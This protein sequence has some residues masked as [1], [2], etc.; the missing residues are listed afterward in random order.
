MKKVLL[1]LL[2][3]TISHFTWAQQVLQVKG[4]V[5][6]KN[7]NPLPGATVTVKGTTTATQTDENGNF[8][9]NAEKGQTL[10]FTYTGLQTAEASITGTNT[11]TVSLNEGSQMDEVVVIG[12]GTIKKKDLTG[13]VASVTGKDLQSNLAKSAAGALQGRIA[14]VSVSNAGGTPGAG[15]SINIRGL[16]SLRSN[17][18]LYVIDGVFGDINLVDPNDIAS[19]EVLKDASAAAI[20]GSRAANGVVIVTT[21]GGRKNSPAVIGINAFTGVQSLPKK[22]D[23]MS[24]PQWKA[25]EKENGLLPAQAE[26]FMAN[27]NWQNEVFHTAPINKV[28][29]DVS[30]GGERST[31]NVSAGYMDQDGILK[32]TGYKAFTIRTKNTFSFFNDHFRMGNT[33]LIKSGDRKYSDLTITDVL[34]QNALLPIYDPAILGGYAT[35][36]PWMKNLEN[37]VGFL[38]LHNKHVYQT[39]IMLNGYAEADLF[40]KGL[41]YRLNVGIN[42]TTGRNYDRGLAY[43]YGTANQQSYLNENAFF[44]N[45][46]LIENTLHYDRTL[47]K[48]TI[49][50]LA[51]YS[52][53]EN[54]SRG[55]GASRKDLPSGTDAINAG[56]LP[57]QSTSGSL[58]EAALISQFGRLVYS[59]DSRYLLT[60]SLRRDGSSKFEDGHRY[61]VFPSIALGWNVMNERFFEAAKNTVNELKVRASYGRLGNQEIPNYTTQNITT[62]GINYIQGGKLWP[63]SITGINWVSRPD[64]T[65]EETVTSNIGL[66]LA[67]LRNKL[68]ISAD[69][70][71]RDTRGVLLNIN[72][73]PSTG[74]TGSPVM[75]A[76]TISN[77]GFEFLATYRNAVGALNYTIGVNA[78]TV[79]NE[80]SAVTVGTVQQFEGFNPRG[81]G[82][83]SWAKVGY[84]IGGFW[85]I[86]TDG[87][88]Q[89]DAEAQA[90]KDAN[91]NVIQPKARGGDIKFVDFNG[92]GRIDNN[93]RQYVGSPFPKLAYGIR[94]GLDYK[95]VDLAFFFDGMY[96]NKIYNYTR[97]R[98]EQ[99]NEVNNHSASLLNSWTPSNTNTDI[100]RYTREDPNDNKRRVSDRWIESGAFF[101]LKTVELGYTL[102]KQWLSKA[103]LKNG[104]IFLAADNLFTATKY[105][106]YTPDL[107]QSNGENGD[108]TG[109]FSAGTDYGRF[110]L[111]R[112]IMFG[113]QANF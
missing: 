105:K 74:L 86:K 101:R 61:G 106:G 67:F 2:L 82:V 23:L 102:P 11:I 107:G 15:L 90:Y 10:E 24:G 44:N 65:W 71:I 109:V 57:D 34:R 51:G 87:L 35:Y 53:Q 28:N 22:M 98:M 63:G 91:G 13:A 12:Y 4:T 56:A 6:D 5:R 113:I 54:T 69:Y 26:S 60:A 79:K 72:Q 75:N 3:G 29:L 37:P 108:Y 59:Y 32:T 33:F 111:A 58:Q 80:V 36:A 84:P 104:R 47:N 40:I 99:T 97:A 42:R 30:G 81:E 52:A 27:T 78:S 45:Q 18:P 25:I 50:V 1:I 92:D 20:Y 19:L 76:G 70:Y 110:P 7:N 94:G 100:P 112:T 9:L 64:L 48:H 68:N 77:K 93:D 8:I 21:K 95:G 83:V 41:K 39:D 31:Y 55:F 62:Y 16:G 85:V 89:S 14:G 43:T 103:T 17:A 46:W 73:P 88:F 96:G 49:H 66:D 38:N